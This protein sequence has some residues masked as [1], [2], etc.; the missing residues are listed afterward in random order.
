MQY[1][2]EIL[3]FYNPSISITHFKEESFCRVISVSS[4]A[5]FPFGWVI[6]IFFSIV[7]KPALFICLGK[8][9]YF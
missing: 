2:L 6:Y 8:M 3:F 4:F 5:I 9:W 1:T 7:L